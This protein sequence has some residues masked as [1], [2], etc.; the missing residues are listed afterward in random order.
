MF[1]NR[2]TTEMSLFSHIADD[3]FSSWFAARTNRDRDTVL[4][5]NNNASDGNGPSVGEGMS[6]IT[7][8]NNAPDGHYY[9]HSGGHTAEPSVGEGMS[10]LEKSS[11][12]EANIFQIDK[13]VNCS[14]EPFSFEFF[15]VSYHRDGISQRWS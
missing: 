1:Q 15:R 4:N 13:Y 6:L 9:S 3:S 14:I 11:S 10:F 12:R 5:V 8:N 2:I 7:I